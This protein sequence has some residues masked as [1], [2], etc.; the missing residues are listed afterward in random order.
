MDQRVDELLFRHLL[1]NSTMPLLGSVIGAALVAIAQIR[2]GDAPIIIAWLGLICATVIARYWITRRCQTR[3]AATGYS[4]RESIRYALTTSMSGLAWGVAGLLVPGAEPL[5]MIIT[6]S[7]IQAMVMGGVLMLGA[8]MPSFLAFSIP[9]VLPAVVFLAYSGGAQNLILSVYSALFLFLMVIIANRVN[10]SLRHT[11][12]LG[13]EKEDLVKALTEARD[14]LAILAGTDGLTG[15]ANRRRFDEVLESE[16]ARLHRS[17]ATLSL[18]FLDVDHF[19]LFNDTYGHV[20]GDQCLKSIAGVFRQFFN[21]SPDFVARY[22]GEEFACIL[23]ETNYEGALLLAE[24][25]R[26]AVAA[27]EIPHRTSETADYVTVSQG[28]VTLDCTK[29]T[30]AAEALEMADCQLYRAK[31]EGRNRVAG[32]CG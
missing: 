6:I 15:V 28:V 1:A 3:I 24:K 32:W 11:L 13:I 19:K 16:F 23:P 7:A 30:T 4:R 18:I 14:Q 2:S 10:Q 22:G 26:S 29:I 25:I 20:S 5:A 27:I 31:L 17:K 8:F 9:A 21:R 12:E